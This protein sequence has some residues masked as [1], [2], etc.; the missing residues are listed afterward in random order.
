M[1]L[2]MERIETFMYLRTDSVL[3]L[4]ITARTYDIHV[5][6]ACSRSLD[7]FRAFEVRSR[8]RV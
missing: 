7:F 2:L 6:C 4:A 3:F 5:S 1:S 8:S